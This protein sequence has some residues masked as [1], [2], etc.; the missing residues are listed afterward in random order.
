MAIPDYADERAE[1]YFEN[2]FVGKSHGDNGS[3][4]KK[5]WNSF[6]DLAPSKMIKCNRLY[7]CAYCGNK[8]LPLQG[9]KG[10]NDYNIYAYTCVCSGAFD[11]RETEAE[12]KKII[13]DAEK[14]A[15]QIRQNMPA[16]NMSV[17]KK[18]AEMNHTRLLKEIID[19]NNSWRIDKT[20]RDLGLSLN[21]HNNH[22]D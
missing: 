20:L 4:Y 14:Q 13:S 18:L 5:F 8:G 16:I 12:A 1:G 11:E 19:D 15:Y 6:S 17:V 9:N 7:Y 2:G 10:T 3:F 22:E 21:S